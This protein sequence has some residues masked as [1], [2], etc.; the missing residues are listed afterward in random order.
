MKRDDIY[1]RLVKNKIEIIPKYYEEGDE[2]YILRFNLTKW[3]F[4]NNLGVK[5]IKF[6]YTR[7]LLPQVEINR[8]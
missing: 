4:L 3:V 2:Y 8:H 5:K 1:C 6:Q 7:I